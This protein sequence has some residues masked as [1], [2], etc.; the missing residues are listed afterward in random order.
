MRLEGSLDAFSL[1]DIFSLLSMTK[2]TGGLHL[3]RSGAHGVVWLGDGSITG[4][5]SDLS[6]LALGRRLAGSGHV[7]D[8][9]LTAAVHEVSRSTDLGLARALRDANAIEEGELHTL[10]FEHIIDTVFDLMRW[11]EGVFEFVI[12]EPNIDDVGVVREVD[13]VVTEARQRLDNWASIDERVSSSD[14]VLSLSLSPE[15]DPSSSAK[16]GRCW[17]WSTASG[18]SLIWSRCAVEASTPS[19]SRWR[20]SSARAW[21]SPKTPKV[22]PHWYDVKTWL[23]PSSQRRHRRRRSS[24]MC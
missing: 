7:T 3:R 10:V 23:L 13:E 24:P 8:D 2:K 4:G 21:S 17:R 15:K 6:R 1:P 22:S 16:S 14:T 11:T 20:R 5:A 18:R 12:D 9:A 19:W